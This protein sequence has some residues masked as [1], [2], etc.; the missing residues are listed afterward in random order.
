MAIH[1]ASDSLSRCDPNAYS[2]IYDVRKRPDIK[3]DPNG[4]PQPIMKDTLEISRDQIKKEALNRLRHTKQIVVPQNSFMRIGKYLFLSIAFP[5]YLLVYGLPKWII[6]EFVPSLFSLSVWMW[7]KVKEN[8]KTPR[9]IVAGKIS[10]AAHYIKQALRSLIQPVVHLVLEIRHGIERMRKN[11]YQFFQR[12]PN[13][14]KERIKNAVNFPRLKAGEIFK[15]MQKRMSQVKEKSFQKIK[16]VSIRFQ[17]GILR[18]TQS[19]QVVLEWGQ[20]QFQQWHNRMAS[21][22][23]PL[24]NRFRSSQQ[25][26]LQ[27]TNWIFKQIHEGRESIK[28]NL[29]PLAAFCREK[30]KP[31]WHQFTRTCQTKWRQMR[32]FMQQKHQK[33]AAFLHQKQEKL[34]KLSFQQFKDRLFSHPV[35]NYLP[36][37]MQRWLKK[38]L[39]HR[40]AQRLYEQGIKVYSFILSALLKASAVL[41]KGIFT[42]SGS[43]LKAWSWFLP[44]AKNG[45]QISLHVL[46]LGWRISR[47][48]FRHGIYYFLLFSTMGG[49]LFIWGLGAL[50][51]LMMSLKTKFSFKS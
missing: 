13:G 21:L 46:S 11:I 43:V 45:S 9:E 22:S 36:E 49:I 38:L 29:K 34:K 24:A 42:G 31:R 25:L 51:D 12:L 16:E 28:R 7:K 6:V 47:K 30:L 18:L 50:G 27:A 8:T 39:S 1:R 37:W 23:R 14:V 41:M 20:L 15:R 4:A 40:I 35:M 5:P 17:E 48:F 32:D 44:Y 19:P 10:Q 2:N 33:A 26:A 3:H